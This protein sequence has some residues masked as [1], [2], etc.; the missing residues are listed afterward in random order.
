MFQMKILHSQSHNCSENFLDHVM[1]KGNWEVYCL[2]L[3][4]NMFLF[5]ICGS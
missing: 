1:M 5:D 4:Q 3:P 2:L